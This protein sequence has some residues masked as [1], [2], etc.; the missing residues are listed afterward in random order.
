M[1]I[2]DE[3][4]IEQLLEMFDDMAC[5]AVYA[6]NNIAM[7]STENRYQTELNRW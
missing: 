2:V 4:V 6:K 3:V 1:K 5:S 7:A